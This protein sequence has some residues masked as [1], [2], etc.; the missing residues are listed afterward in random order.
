MVQCATATQMPKHKWAMS[1]TIRACITDTNKVSFPQPDLLK[2]AEE[3]HG[4]LAGRPS[5]TLLVTV[6]V[7]EATA[8]APLIAGN[9]IITP[10][11]TIRTVTPTRC[12]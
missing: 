12:T 11:I 4:A 2:A 10:Q 9:I 1:H 7:F 6:T 3:F 5:A 8:T